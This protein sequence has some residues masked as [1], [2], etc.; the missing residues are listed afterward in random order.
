MSI[1]ALCG[2]E[3]ELR[4]SHIIPS[5]VGKWSK[6]TSATGFL[7]QSDD[8]SV[9]VQDFPTLPLL[10]SD[11]EQK[12]SSLESY[13]ASKV[14]YPFHN[15]KVREFEYDER[16]RLFA[17]SLS[18]RTLKANCG[19]EFK[20]AVP[21]LVSQVEQAEIDWRKILLQGRFDGSPYETH[22]LL[23][24]YV[25][26]GE[27]VPSGLQRY[28]L[29]TVDACIVE[30]S[31]RVM[32]YTKLPWMVFATAIFPVKLDGWEKTIIL[33]KG[34]ISSPQ[35][36]T[37]GYF[38]TFLHD[39]ARLATEADLPKWRKEAILKDMR[40]NP[41]RLLQS[42]SLDV[43][44]AEKDIE[45]RRKMREMPE[46]VQALVIEGVAEA[47][48]DTGKSKEE[49]QISRLVGR[50]IADALANLSK[51]EAAEL[52]G[53]MLGTMNY[54]KMRG[55]DALCRFRCDGVWV[56]FIV[57]PYSTKE[58]QRKKIMEEMEDVKR[59][60]S[61]RK[62]TPIAVFSLHVDDDGTGFEMGF[63]MDAQSSKD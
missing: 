10:C 19:D 39:R 37:D 33:D 54:S 56:S 34:E 47:L 6:S 49:N 45:R 12:F 60:S 7:S 21:E 61:R 24:D 26:K 16:L 36:I 32:V 40:K 1:C 23:L 59:D 18:W 35:T 41:T 38:G 44:I 5:F 3:G 15:K 50:K 29:R 28:M 63:W 27:G 55:G 48:D 52:G 8:L 22:F 11:C 4:A 31:G 13:F 9:R 43:L 42:A 2:K 25:K 17:L 62:T 46:L 30:G 51:E 14:F 58:Y 53:I 57:N 20:A